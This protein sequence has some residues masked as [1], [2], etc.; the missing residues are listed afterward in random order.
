MGVNADEPLQLYALPRFFRKSPPS[1]G[2]I[3]EMGAAPNQERHQPD[4]DP[5]DRPTPLLPYTGVS[6][7][8]TS[9]AS[10]AKRET[11]DAEPP[12]GAARL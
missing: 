9:R 5:P 6:L 3:G 10:T 4:S 8:R 12:L 1:R 2:D 7:F 11:S